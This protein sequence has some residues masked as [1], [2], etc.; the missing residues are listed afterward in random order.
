MSRPD[1]GSRRQ[2]LARSLRNRNFRKY[3]VGQGLSQ[4]GMWMQQTAE[5]WLILELTGNAAALGLHSVLRFGP[6]LLFGVHAGL[7]TD[8]FDR[9]R[10]LLATQGLHAFAAAVLAYLTWV[11]T[12]TLGLIYAVV[13]IQGIVNAVD[14]PVRRAFVRDLVGDQDLSNAISLKSS[15]STVTKTLGPALGG[16]VLAAWG[17]QTCFT[18]NAISYLAVLIVR[19]LIDK[20]R[21]RPI[22]KADRSEHQLREGFRFACGVSM[23]FAALLV[24]AAVVAT[25]AWN[26]NVVLPV[27]ANTSLGGDSRLY[28]LLVSCVGLGSFVGA[29]N[30][31]RKTH[32]TH[33]S[34]T[35]GG[36]FLGLS[37]SA[38]RSLR[39]CRLRSWHWACW[40][41]PARHC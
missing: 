1:S 21:T 5:L 39:P 22:S 10:L 25:F 11:S 34:L 7:L 17:V 33:K 13:L 28:G 16:L 18:I 2:N 31:A 12:P 37:C 23:T 24:A 41:L 20:P 6:I 40:V 8:R 27:Y 36:A 29:I 15:V 3:V 35:R 30:S 38:S 19:L 32:I 14:N 26:W 9:R 4:T